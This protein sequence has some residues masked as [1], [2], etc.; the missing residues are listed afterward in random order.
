VTGLL[1]PVDAGRRTNPHNLG[2]DACLL[3]RSAMPEMLEAVDLVPARMLNEFTYCPRLAYL[4]WVQGE[5]ADNPD[6]LDGEFVHRNAD[7]PDRQPIRAPVADPE[8]EA[9]ERETIHARSVRLE[10]VELGL[11]AV[12]DVLEVEGEVATPVD[13]KKGHAP[14]LPEG[15]WEPERVQL[16]AQ[17][18]L[19]REAGFRC[20]EGII[21][22]SASRRRVRIPFDDAL[23]ARTRELI[24]GCRAMAR[25]G[26]MPLP[27]VDSPKCP[28]CSLVGICLPDET[29]VLLRETQPVAEATEA[30][31]PSSPR[32]LLAPRPE[33]IPLHVVEPGARLS[34]HGDRL[35]V[36]RKGEKLA[37]VRLKDISQVC[38]FGPVQTSTQVMN[39]LFDRDIPVCYFS[40]GGW[41]RGIA[42]GLPHKNIELRIRQHAV[43]ADAGQALGLARQFVAGKIRN[44]RTLLRRNGGRDDDRLLD[45]L[46]ESARQAERADNIASLMGIEGMAA[47]RYFAGFATLLKE[48][49]GYCFDG[50]NRRPPADPVNATLS[51]LYGML[52]R[53][54]TAATLACGLDPYL[55]F[56]HQPRYG[57]PALALDLAE[58][59][60][61]LLADSTA[62]SLFNTGELKPSDF[63]CRAGAVALKP[64]GRKAVLA[65]WERRLLSDV[66]HPVFGYTLSYRRVLMVQARLL[67]RVL[68]G[69]L[70]EYPAFKTR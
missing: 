24:A 56:L 3:W 49:R 11:V 55:G 16:C 52:T 43:A 5:W 59:F 63:V 7:R 53:E 36:E 14:D 30:R 9:G 70:P 22:F 6:T 15:A 32:L 19:L 60:R 46:A 57:R 67:G 23:V 41:F 66:T 28:R 65:A 39:E 26:S 51:F 10:S 31:K 34:K 27:L 54:L 69:E 18:L 62:L 13:Y 48:D 47:K 64:G 29:N 33:S 21:W 68:S 38:L 45:A 42:H 61:P 35:H 8:A 37:E 40:S 4:E 17:G 44:C 1:A 50:R 20:D 12:V 25:G 2:M 58:E